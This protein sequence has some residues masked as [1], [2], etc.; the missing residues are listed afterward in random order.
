[1]TVIPRLM[2]VLALVLAPVIVWSTAP[3]LPERVATHFGP[4]GLPN[5]WM[6]R[7][8]YLAFMLAMSTLLPLFVVATTGLLPRWAPSL[9]R[10]RNR[11][12]WFAP[13]RREA[14]LGW[15]L[16]HALWL[17]VVLCTFLVAVH[18]LIVQANVQAPARLAESQLVTAV[19]VFL[20]ALAIWIATMVARFRRF[21]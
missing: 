12:H 16:N 17:G 15:L 3:G 4:G 13:A 21:R 14:T 20:I 11:E 7:D 18:L 1:M 5:G 6:P 9:S 19:V 2:F 10:I 8:G